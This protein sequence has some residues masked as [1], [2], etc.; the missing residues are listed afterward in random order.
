MKL[1]IVIPAYNE[2][3]GIGPTLDSIPTS[4]LIAAG[5]EVEKLV[6]NNASTDLTAIVALKHGARVVFQSKRGY[7][8]AYQTGFEHA[9]GDIIASGDADMTY[10][11]DRLPEILRKMKDED[12][13]FLNTD[14]LSNLRHG[15]MQ[16]SHIF[17]NYVLSF[18]M[19]LLFNVPFKDSQSGMWI[20]KRSIWQYLTVEHTGMPF[21]QEIKIEAYMKG[22]RCA[23]L[24]IEYRNRIGSEKLSVIDAW[25]T[26]YELFKKRFT[27]KKEY[28]D[29]TTEEVE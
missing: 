22:F 28:L 24:P 7:G 5:Y 20:F 10:P 25:R 1:T 4:E 18:I 26:M 2:E 12:L 9:T 15:V 27:L 17:G 8:N 23:E 3:D 6:V 19:H 11:F 29:L 14:R 13:D 21:S 16:P